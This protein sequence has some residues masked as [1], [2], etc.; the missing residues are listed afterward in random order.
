MGPPGSLEFGHLQSSAEGVPCH[1]LGRFYR[2]GWE[3]VRVDV[4][5]AGH[6]GSDF[7]PEEDR[8]LVLVLSGEIVQQVLSA[9]DL[10]S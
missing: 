5:E 7:P 3:K 6:V 8:A 10:P 4:V 2:L 1:P 9:G